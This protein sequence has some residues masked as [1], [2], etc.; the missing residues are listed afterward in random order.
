MRPVRSPLQVRRHPLEAADRDRF[1][2]DSTAPAG[3][4]AGAIAHPAQYAGEHVGLAIEQIG[5]GKAPLGNEPDV[6]RYVGV[7]GTGPLAVYNAM[8][9]LRIRGICRVHLVSVYSKTARILG[10]N[11]Q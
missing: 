5:V 10:E 11:V 7:R 3:R 4:L 6:L 9:M 1:V 8:I 2:L